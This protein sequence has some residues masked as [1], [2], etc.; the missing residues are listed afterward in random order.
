[1]IGRK[2]TTL[3]KFISEKDKRPYTEFI[4]EVYE[5]GVMLG[6]PN[7]IALIRKDKEAI[8]VANLAA[9]LKNKLHS[10]MVNSHEELWDR[11]WLEDN[12]ST[13]NNNQKNLAKIR[14]KAILIKK[15]QIISAYTILLL[16]TVVTQIFLFRK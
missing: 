16:P 1:M 10:T 4:D 2:Y 6:M 8:P 14:A 5:K 11:V 7:S 3:L 9:P 15:V 13:S 12:Q